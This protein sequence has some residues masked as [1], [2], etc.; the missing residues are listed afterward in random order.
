MTFFMLYVVP[1]L[2]VLGWGM[3]FAIVALVIAALI[4]YVRG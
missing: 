2:A 4:K 3:C 1:V